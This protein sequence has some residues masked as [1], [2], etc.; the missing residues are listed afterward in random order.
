MA[1]NLKDSALYYHEKPVPGK[2]AMVPTKPMATQHDLSLA[3]SPGVAHPCIALAEDPTTAALYTARQNLVGVITNGTAVLGL[4]NI[5]PLA[6]KPVMEGKA[7]LFKKFADINVFDIEI[8]EPEVDRFVDVV[9]ALEPT[10][11]GINLED[12]K[13]PEC[14]EI[15]SKLRK[16]MN[17]PVFHDDQHGTAICVA[18]AIF[19]AL[20][21][22]DKQ[23]D[24]I[25]LVTSGAGAAAMACVN[26]LVVMG[27]KIENVILTDIDGVV[28]TGRP[29]MNQVIA[30]YARNTP[31]RTLA[32]AIKGA[33]IFLGLSVPGVLKP[34]MIKS[35]NVNPIIMSLANP[36]PEIMPEEAKA[37]RED[38]IIA[39][40]RSDYPNQVNNVLCFP[41]IFRGALDVG[42][43]T[44][45]E[46]MK[47]AAVSAIADLAMHEASDV[48]AS[49]YSGQE[50]LSFGSEYLIPKPFD[51]RLIIEIAPRVAQAAMNSKVATRPIK[52]FSAYRQKLSQFVYRSGQVMHP[53]FS[54]ARELPKRVV[55]AEGEEER[56][57]RAVQSILDEKLAY[58]ILI[59][60]PDVIENNLAKLGL[61]LKIGCEVDVI[62]I[63]KESRYELYCTAYHKLMERRGVS[64][65]K[66]LEIVRTNNTVI[67]SLMMQLGEAEAAI[68][69]TVGQYWDHLDHVR[70]IIGTRNGINELAAVSLLI[71]PQGP[72]FMVDT[73]V[74]PDP[75]A[76]A[77]VEMVDLVINEVLSFGI[78][79][80]VAFVSHSHFGSSDKPSAR[81][82]REAVSKLAI[83][84]PSLEVEGEMQADSAL[85]EVVRNRTFPNSRLSGTANILVM[86]TLDS[87]NVAF[88]LMK[89]AAQG[90]SVGPMLIGSAK[91]IHILTQSVTVRGIINMTAVAVV[92][93]Q[94]NQIAR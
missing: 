37:V 6:S 78:E 58:P 36:I 12:I 22:V 27:L 67:A 18:A 35:M 55:F 7:V 52:D 46:E 65:K 70:Q 10:F 4:G 77:L 64:L 88:N 90:L 59:G 62:D 5:G 94:A 3:Y 79:P 8:A 16:R 71:L 32:E 31:M 86:P 87:A 25:R 43:T 85:S 66:A 48:V 89:T 17:I 30:R 33:D 50:E 57:L 29:Q 45:N 39:T 24:S 47:I 2:M 15:E 9:A 14:F 84:H 42:A 80:K 40:G 53:I 26:L 73:H 56:V 76:D 54:K 19:N 83:K 1:Q 92:D 11:G 38:V 23:F 13:A 44:I 49:A 93:A 82:M 63:N 20:R 28:Y 69:G 21:L 68:C 81:K 34:N 41:F 72:Y 74:T 60:R 61:R 51:P 91:P 75:S